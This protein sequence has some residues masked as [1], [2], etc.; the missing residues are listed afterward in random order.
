MFVYAHITDPAGRLLVLMSSEQHQWVLP[1]GEVGAHETRPDAVAYHAR[2]ILRVP[3]DPTGEEMAMHNGE[4]LINCAA[5]SQ[6]RIA[7]I[8]LPPRPAGKPYPEFRA[9][10]FVPLTAL[11]SRMRPDHRH[12]VRTAL[13]RGSS[14]SSRTSAHT[15]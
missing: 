11:P 6:R 4:Y 14:T 3:V 15:S 9:F 8:N 2:R 5:I 10:D 1:G 13:E 7:R 12:L